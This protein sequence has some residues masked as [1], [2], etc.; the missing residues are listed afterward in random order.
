MKRP[1]LTRKMIEKLTIEFCKENGPAKGAAIINGGGVYMSD[2]AYC[3]ARKMV[4]QHERWGGWKIHAET[5]EDAKRII[6]REIVSSWPGASR[7]NYDCAF[8][9]TKLRTDPLTRDAHAAAEW[10][11]R[12]SIWKTEQ[13]K[14]KKEKN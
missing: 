7:K 14:K 9:H 3:P 4:S 12:V 6:E 1:P 11:T 8:Q 5:E 10:I 13:E 2:F